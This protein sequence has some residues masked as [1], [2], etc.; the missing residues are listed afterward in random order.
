MRC[1]LFAAL[2]ALVAATAHADPPV[3]FALGVSYDRSVKSGQNG[4][5]FHLTAD[6][7]KH[8]RLQPEF[9]YLTEHND[10]AT[11]QLNL[12]AHWRM[13]LFD[14]FGI[15]PLVGMSYSHWGYTGPNASRWGMNAGC[16]A[17]YCFG[18]RVSLFTEV[19]LLV[20][21]HETQPIYTVGLKYHL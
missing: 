7:G 2:L 9:I 11:L 14:S 15:Y 13:P 19:R 6:L 18:G 3:P 4:Y 17:E 12:N 16:G 5:G 10:V 21:S 1:F 20:V 8:V